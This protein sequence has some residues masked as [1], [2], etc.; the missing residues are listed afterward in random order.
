MRP[1]PV[2][3]EGKGAVLKGFRDF[4]MRGNVVKLAVAVVI[5]TAF[6]AVVTAFTN[7]IIKPA[8]ALAGGANVPGWGFY[9]NSAKP[10]TFIDLSAAINAVITFVITA[11]VVYFMFVLPAQKIQERRTKSSDQDQP[12]ASDVELLA[13]IRNLL[14]RSQGLPTVD[15]LRPAPSDEDATGGS[16]VSSTDKL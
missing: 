8:I 16:P 15:G 1:V 12:D 11:A 14:R 9:L 5:G 10:A 3:L 6:T 4:L 2:E 7:S 13:E